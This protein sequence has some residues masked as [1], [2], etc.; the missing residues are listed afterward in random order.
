[1]MTLTLS[2]LL[3]LSKTEKAYL[4]NRE[5][6]SKRQQRDIRCRLNKKLRLLNQEFENSGVDG[7]IGVVCY[8]YCCSSPPSAVPAVSASVVV[9]VVA[10]AGAVIIILDV[11][12]IIILI[13]SLKVVA[14]TADAMRLLLFLSR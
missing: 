5:Q 7:T 6:F 13:A 10:A 14:A 2:L 9:V 12:N 11:A 8:C 1:M 3:L 4:N